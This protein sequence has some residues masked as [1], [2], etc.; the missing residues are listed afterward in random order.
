MVIFLRRL[1]T[2]AI[3]LVWLNADNRASLSQIR[4]RSVFFPALKHLS[5][6]ALPGAMTK[7][8]DNAKKYANDDL[9]EH[10]Q[11]SPNTT[12]PMIEMTWQ[13]RTCRQWI[14]LESFVRVLPTKQLY[15]FFDITWVQ[16]QRWDLFCM[17]SIFVTSF[18]PSQISL[19]SSLCLAYD[20]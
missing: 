15:F 13:E 11:V 5:P 6:S 10:C 4:W 19:F 7:L 2:C 12:T 20:S 9:Y 16:T 1:W 17:P 14:V 8:C 3:P 18:L